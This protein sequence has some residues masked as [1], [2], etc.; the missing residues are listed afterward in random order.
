MQG[1]TSQ[2]LALKKN[3]VLVLLQTLHYKSSCNSVNTK[4]FVTNFFGLPLENVDL[5]IVP[6]SLW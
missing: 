3:A 1:G 2:N 5:S 6:I 4:I